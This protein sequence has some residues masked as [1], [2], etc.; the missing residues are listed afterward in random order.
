MS[1]QFGRWNLDGK[2]VSQGYLDKVKPVIAPYGPDDSGSYAK[3]SINILYRAFHTTKESRT[4][5]SL[6]LR[7]PAPSSLGTAAW[8]IAQSSSGN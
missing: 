5:L 4:K 2:P 7:N 8:T 3:T 6:T 1:V